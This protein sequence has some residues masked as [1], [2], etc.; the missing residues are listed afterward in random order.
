MP[1]SE[2]F[3][4]LLL[5]LLLLLMILNHQSS[6][7]MPNHPLSVNNDSTS[8]PMEANKG[9]VDRADMEKAKVS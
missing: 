5:R 1:L 9:R 3:L 4:A 6:I 7:Q 8:H 2:E